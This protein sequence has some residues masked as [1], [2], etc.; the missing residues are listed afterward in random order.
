MNSY[1]NCPLISVG[2]PVYNGEKYLQL[3]LESLLSQEYRN[4]EIIISDNASTDATGDICM[5]FVAQDSR[6]KY[7]K[8]EVNKGIAY[9]FQR[10]FDL[11]KG[12]YFM[13]AAH[14]DLFDKTF[15]A[16]CVQKLEE[17]PDA[18]LCLSDLI[19]IDED[20]KC[21]TTTYITPETVGKTILQSADHIFNNFGWYDT[22]GLYRLETIKDRKVDLSRFGADVSFT[23]EIMLRGDIVKVNEPLFYYRT[24]NKSFEEFLMNY[25]KPTVSE[26]KTPYSNLARDLIEVIKFSR[27]DHNSKD[28]LIRNFIDIL[29]HQNEEWKNL[30][31]K[32]YLPP[33]S[34]VSLEQQIALIESIVL[35][36]VDE[37]ILREDINT[38][39]QGNHIQSLS[40]GRPIYVWGGGS[41]GQRVAELMMQRKI[42]IEG[43]I[44]SNSLKWEKRLLDKKILSPEV[45]LESNCE[46]SKR[47]FIV[48]GSSYSKEI[49]ASLNTRGYVETTDFVEVILN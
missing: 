12:K 44:D 16:K 23:L 1:A 32:E 30:I 38:L 2:L 35:N 27:I 37:G 21:S 25:D 14:D 19:F 3:A 6:I 49:R 5:N 40:Q 45:V 11:S 15:I 22:Y 8:E 17:S 24:S 33:L 39:L 46:L 48:I 13:W 36:Y 4:I 26:I 34:V 31:I 42:E 7:S 43:F 29:T 9:N 18:L 10:V 41:A 20:G 28:Q 47:A